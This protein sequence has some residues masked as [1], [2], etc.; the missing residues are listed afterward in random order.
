MCCKAPD[1]TT[2]PVQVTTGLS[3]RAP[4]S[5]VSSAGFSSSIRNT[6][7]GSCPAL[8][9]RFR[10]AIAAGPRIGMNPHSD[11]AWPRKTSPSRS[12]A[13]DA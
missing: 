9:V 3:V 12:N 5:A 1:G 10:S 2:I 11:M 7:T 13:M 6:T 8:M 4:L